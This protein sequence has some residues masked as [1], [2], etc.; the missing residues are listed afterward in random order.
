VHEVGVFGGDVQY[1]EC[2]GGDVRGMERGVNIG[3][4]M[5]GVHSGESTVNDM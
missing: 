3:G 1:G 5:R 4:Y 2:N